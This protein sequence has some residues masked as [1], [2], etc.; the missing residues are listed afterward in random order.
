MFSMRHLMQQPVFLFRPLVLREPRLS[1][2]LCALLT[3]NI[4]VLLKTDWCLNVTIL[5]A[6]SG[7]CSAAAESLTFVL[8]CKE[9]QYSLESNIQC[10]QCSSLLLVI[11]I[12]FFTTSGLA[13]VSPWINNSKVKD[14]VWQAFA[15]LEQERKSLKC[16]NKTNLL[17][18]GSLSIMVIKLI[19]IHLE[20]AFDTDYSKA[21]T[22]QVKH[23]PKTQ[24]TA[25]AQIHNTVFQ[26]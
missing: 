12:N 8:R 24:E 18:V 5:L 19:S 3:C 23:W 21:L 1:E 20:M 14:P 7:W 11:Y 10:S 22:K 15:T 16:Y 6:E 2:P 26:I 13:N 4:T 9:I 17:C 25:C